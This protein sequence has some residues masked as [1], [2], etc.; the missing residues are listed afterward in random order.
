MNRKLVGYDVVGNTPFEVDATDAANVGGALQDGFFIIQWL[1][2]MGEAEKI[3][4][5]VMSGD[6]SASLRQR[7]HDAGAVGFF[8]K[9]IDHAALL[10]AIHKALAG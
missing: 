1:R 7:A 5:I 10:D 2:R 9:P 4:I 8:T 6:G 3:P